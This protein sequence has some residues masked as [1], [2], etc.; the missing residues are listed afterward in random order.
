[1]IGKRYKEEKKAIGENQY[2][3]PSNIQENDGMNI[4]DDQRA[5]LIGKKYPEEM[6]D[7]SEIK[8]EKRLRRMRHYDAPISTSKN[9]ANQ[10]NVSYRTVE[11]A[12]KF[13]VKKLKM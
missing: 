13:A 1:L 12:E 9:I 10:A 2:T 4:S 3:I 6:N 5:Y 7:A 8:E 11:R